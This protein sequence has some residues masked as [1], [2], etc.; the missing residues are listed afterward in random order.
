MIFHTTDRTPPIRFRRSTP[1]YSS[2]TGHFCYEV[3]EG[4]LVYAL[5]TP[6]GA[7]SDRPEY[8]IRG[9][10]LFRTQAHPAGFSLDADYEIRNA[11]LFRTYT[12]HWGPKTQPDYDVVE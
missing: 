3:R 12:H 11:Q 6:F 2:F 10:F 8:E 1:S 9:R 5:K 4:G 7:G